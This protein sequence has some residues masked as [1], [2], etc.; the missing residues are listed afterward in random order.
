MQ[1]L[2]SLERIAAINRECL[3]AGGTG[4]EGHHADHTPFYDLDLGR[5]IFQVP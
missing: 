1:S 3:K 2:A 4:S 5:Q